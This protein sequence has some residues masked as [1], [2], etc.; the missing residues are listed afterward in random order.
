MPKV[1][2]QMTGR[3]LQIVAV[4]LMIAQTGCLATI[5]GVT[6]GGAATGYLYYKGRIYR[7]FPASLPDVHNAVH[8][9]LLDLKFPIL[10]EETKDGKTFFL[11]RTTED[12]KVRIY[13]EALT[14]PIP[15]ESRLTRVSI[16]VATFGNEGVSARILDQVSWYFTR[17]IVPGGAPV[18]IQQTSGV[19]TFETS[20]PPPAPQPVKT[21]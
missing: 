21:K 15:A 6:A 18:P 13:V 17:Q 10:T 4:V 14:S 12:K 8:A 20:E 2:M 9:A 3:A 1:K 7:D 11:T 19:R 16:R 5:I